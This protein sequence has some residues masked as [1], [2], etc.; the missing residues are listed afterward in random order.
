MD[1][2]VSICTYNGEER[3]QEVLDCLSE[4]KKIDK[5]EWEVIVVNN[6]STDETKDVVHG[7]KKEWSQSAPLKVVTER[8]QGLAFARQRA[9]D[10]AAGRWVAFLD[11]DNLPAS[12]WVFE[13]VSFAK[14][15]PSAGAFGGQLIGEYE[16][17]PPRTFGLVKGLFAINECKETFSYSEMGTGEFAPGAGLVVRRDAWKQ[18]VP[19]K[20]SSTGVSQGSRADVGEDIEAQWYLHQ[21]GWDVWHNSDMVARHKMPSDRF[22]PEYLKRFFEGIGISR[23]RTRMMRF[24]WWQQ[25]FMILAFW[26]NDLRKLCRLY[27]RY[28]HKL[29]DRFVQG[30]ILLLKT[31]LSRPFNLSM[32]D[33]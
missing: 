29:D 7:Y 6:N 3:V 14:E 10:E 33:Q 23:H 20:L 11:D 28:R 9:I 1:I 19:D 30:R 31:M 21:A 27:W 16:V 8:K 32:S 13:A 5:V 12:D 22:E 26:L 15:H 4:Q 18:H 17:D 24:A 2:T 25:P